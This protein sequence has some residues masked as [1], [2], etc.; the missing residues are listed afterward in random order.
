[1]TGTLHLVGTPIGNLGDITQRAIATLQGV[2]RIFAEDTR[3][4]RA[5]LTALGIRGKPVS[6]LHA[7]S[8]PKTLATALEILREGRD[9]ALVTDAGM[10]G[11]S[12]P[13]RALVQAARSARVPVTAEPGPSAVTTAVALSGLVE[14]P[15]LFLGFLPR[16]GR[17]RVETLER[18]AGSDV[19]VVLFESPLRTTATLRDLAALDPERRASVCRELTK[20]FEE[21]RSGSLS[22]LAATEEWRGEITMVIEGAPPKSTTS[23]DEPPLEERI[24][25]LIA[26][27]HS[28]KDIVTSLGR[29]LPGRPKRSLYAQVQAQIE[30]RRSSEDEEE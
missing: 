3:R 12:D 14:G 9:I 4:T 1:M 11:I 22:E 18:I 7:H 26:Q 29:A 13:G 16:K 23:D 2:D 21:V 17:A 6:A 8:S 20:Q 27:G 5:L 24:D 19:P 25:A 15:F 10:P 28:V 30:S